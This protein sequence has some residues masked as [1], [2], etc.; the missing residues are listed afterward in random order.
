MADNTSFDNDDNVF[1]TLGFDNGD[2]V[3]SSGP[4]PNDI[5]KITI[6][7]IIRSWDEAPLEF[8]EQIKEYIETNNVDLSTL[9][10]QD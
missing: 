6:A 7:Q 5:E 8:R 3:S 2:E 1:E 10:S 4:D 9:C